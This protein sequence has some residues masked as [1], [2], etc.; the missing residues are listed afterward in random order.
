[1]QKPIKTESVNVQGIWC[2]L[3]G[4]LTEFLFNVLRD[5]DIKHTLHQGFD[6]EQ[7]GIDV[8]E[9]RHGLMD[10]IRIGIIC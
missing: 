8:L 4:K 7:M 1:M 9:I 10:R 6:G 2:E 3:P 5:T